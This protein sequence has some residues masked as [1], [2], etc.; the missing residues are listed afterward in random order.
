MLISFTAVAEGFNWLVVPTDIKV[1]LFGNEIPS[2][3]VN[4]QMYIAVEDMAEYGYH[5]GYDASLRALYASYEGTTPTGKEI[6]PVD[7]RTLTE[8]DIPVYIAGEKITGYAGE[9][10][11]YVS[12]SALAHFRD[13]NNLGDAGVVG[14]PYGLASFWDGEKRTL[15]LDKAT[16]NSK[17]STEEE[18]LAWINP[19]DKFGWSHIGD[20]QGD[21]FKVAICA[22][23][24]TPHGTYTNYKYYGDDGRIFSIN[25]LFHMYG[26]YDY[27]GKVKVQEVKLEGNSLYFNGHRTD[28]RTGTYYLNLNSF[29]LNPIK[30]TPPD[31]SNRTTPI[32]S[33]FYVSEYLKDATFGV[34]L[35]GMKINGYVVGSQCYINPDMLL[36][37][38]Y[39]KVKGGN[40]IIY[41]Y[42]GNKSSFTEPYLTGE[43]IE[44]SG[45]P[46]VM[47][48]GE[49]LRTCNF[50]DYSL[51]DTAHFERSFANDVGITAIWDGENH[52]L[53]ISTCLVRS[54]E[55]AKKYAQD[56]LTDPSY[57]LK[58][59]YEGDDYSILAS[60][61]KEDG[62]FIDG[63]KISSRGE[64]TDLARLYYTVYGIS[65]VY[66]VTVE[67]HIITLK[68]HWNRTFALD[69]RNF[70]VNE[71]I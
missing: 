26:F 12:A 27:W 7:V 59:L 9:G 28:G 41:T 13:G 18:Y 31:D 21:G 37:L 54:Y 58:Y 49:Q 34:Y 64:V 30:E 68:T 23:N 5:I 38:G 46:F 15:S 36:N 56:K 40:H 25:S 1:T 35:D 51:V 16:Y 63:C 44:K 47:I 57:E 45:T 19:D 55:E 6:L 70:T 17:I 42:T 8:S 10:K 53:N 14:Y 69:L 71:I 33:P 66:E 24:G 48:N 62:R 22:Q 29:R 60:F 65:Q 52:R 61:G 20:L 67:N 43:K 4:N 50:G 39:E 32:Y 3:C 11:M 2:V